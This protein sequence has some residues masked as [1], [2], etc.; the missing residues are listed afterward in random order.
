MICAEYMRFRL[1]HSLWI[2][3]VADV[4]SIDVDT[5]VAQINFI[6]V[7]V[8]QNINTTLTSLLSLINARLRMFVQPSLFCCGI[9]LVSKNTIIPRFFPSSRFLSF[10]LHF[11]PLPLRLL[12]WMNLL[13]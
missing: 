10:F 3:E 9:D 8:I 4:N 7:I 5:G 12:K 2:N 13:D 6:V 1:Q 11:S